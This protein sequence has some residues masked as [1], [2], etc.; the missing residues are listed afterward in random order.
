MAVE[1]FQEAVEMF[2]AAL[3]QDP[4]RK[5]LHYR[6]GVA[7]EAAGNRDRAAVEYRRSLDEWR[8]ADPD[9]PHVAEA[10]ERLAAN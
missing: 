5:Y 4:Y 6:L 1:Q 8:N 2:E 9:A 3:S 7:L 10:R